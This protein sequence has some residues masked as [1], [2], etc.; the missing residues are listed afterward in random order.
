[1]EDLEGRTRNSAFSLSE[2]AAAQAAAAQAAGKA[3]KLDIGT[4]DSADF[5]NLPSDKQLPGDVVRIRNAPGAVPNLN[6]DVLPQVLIEKCKSPDAINDIKL[7]NKLTAKIKTAKATKKK[8]DKWLK[9]AQMAL[10]KLEGQITT[11]KI[12]QNTINR[13][14]DGMSHQRRQ[15][16][17]RLKSIKLKADLE[18]AKK[19]MKKLNAYG[20]ILGRT[21]SSLVQGKEQM[22]RRVK[23]LKKGIKHLQTFGQDA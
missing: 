19:K 20:K 15:I 18:A 5:A 9:V 17:K 22:S 23:T 6:E 7:W 2:G 13:A 21:Q 1:M 8:Y 16:V 14:I 10:K 12:N 11:T 3:G 4:F